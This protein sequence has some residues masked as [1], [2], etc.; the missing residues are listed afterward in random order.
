[1]LANAD[2]LALHWNAMV[3]SARGVLGSRAEA[4]DC[5]GQ[6]M[7]QVCEQNLDLVVNLEAYMVTVA[8]RRAIDRR[9]HLERGRHR[10]QRLA[11]QERTS[12]DDHA[13][14]VARRSE[15]RWMAEQA[16]RLLDARSMD[17]LRR[18]ADGEPM[19]SIAAFHHMREGAARTVLYRARKLLKEVYARGLAILGIGWAFA[20][21]TSAPTAATLTA[22]GVA[23]LTLMP[24]LSEQ[25]P[26]SGAL[27][28]RQ[29]GVAAAPAPSATQDPTPS[30]LTGMTPR[31]T[32]GAVR[33]RSSSTGV[34]PGP[35]IIQAP[36]GA[37]VKIEKERRGD[38]TVHEPTE[39]LLHCAENLQLTLQ[40]IGC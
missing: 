30:R 4:E 12:C 39:I 18:H 1:M 37:G 29:P 7:L 26:S 22:L 10:D 8:K 17:I 33:P 5:A 9:R 11:A 27:L 40:H 34:G 19:D 2:D 6:A 38:E 21:R 35:V 32:S 20:R 28:Q 14:D 24:N 3:R 31:K 25:P 16:E 23:L 36:G 15:A 13:E